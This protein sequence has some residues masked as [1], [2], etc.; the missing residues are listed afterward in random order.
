[1]IDVATSK[2]GIIPSSMCGLIQGIQGH[3][4]TMKTLK[5]TIS[6]KYKSIGTVSKLYREVSFI[7]SDVEKRFHYSS[8]ESLV[9]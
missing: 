8:F 7:Q 1:L 9:F 3:A 2:A 4:G 5:N 6:C